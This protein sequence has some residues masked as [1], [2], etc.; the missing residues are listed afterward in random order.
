MAHD[1]NVAVVNFVMLVIGLNMVAVNSGAKRGQG[2]KRRGE[3]R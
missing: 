2:E 1:F 3:L